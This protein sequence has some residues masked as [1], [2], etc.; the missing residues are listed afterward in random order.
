MQSEQL[1][2]LHQDFAKQGISLI[3]TK[4]SIKH[5]N[6]RVKVDECYVSVPSW[7]SCHDIIQAIRLRVSWAVKTNQKLKQKIAFHR[8][9]EQCLWGQH[10][11]LPGNERQILQIYR[12]ALSIKLPQLMAKWQPVVGKSASDVRLKKMKSRWGTCNTRNARVWLSVYLA[13]YPYECTEYVFVHELCHLIHPNHSSL[14]W[15][16]VKKVMP[17]YQK[18]HDLLK[19]RNEC[20]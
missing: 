6:F 10:V 11:D 16:E 4:K 1:H 12:Q 15:M 7:V 17:N 18:W 8:A 13:A 2:Q 20:L 3:I 19:A 14:F 5:I 9:Y